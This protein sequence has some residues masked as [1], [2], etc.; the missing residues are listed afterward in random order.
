MIDRYLL[1]YFL[2][3]V[4]EGTFSRA[5]AHCRVTQPTLSV[6]IAK[7]ETLL[8]HPLFERSSRRVALTAA[9]ARLAEHARRIEAGFV[10]AEQ[11]VGDSAAAKL[12]RLGLCTTLPDAWLEEALRAAAPAREA[13]ERLELVEGRAGE[14]R[15]A[16]HRGRVD[17]IVAPLD[18]ALPHR[19]L[20]DEPY[21][22]AFARDHPLA[23]RVSVEAEE[24]AA[25]P[26]VVRRHCEMLAETSRF[27]TARGIRPFMAARTH[28][29]SRALAYVRAGVA[30]TLLP[31]C[32][33]DP[34]L[35]LV[36]LAG[37]D[38]RRT[39]ALCF[40]P[41]SRARAAHSVVLSRIA[42]RLAELAQAGAATFTINYTGSA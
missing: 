1:R 31:A 19:V 20:F 21:A 8:G 26:M 42:E 27:F 22:M 15:A 24:L 38:H 4:D 11:A 16:L 2:A 29:D 34:A 37:F 41:D 40:A 33:A 36:P 5:A 39:V 13:G 17:A 7:L 25:E 30:T 35:A 32:Y 23:A 18:A 9:G 14:L 3:V 12:I 6:G 28:S 10:A